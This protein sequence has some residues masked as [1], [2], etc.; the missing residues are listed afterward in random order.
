M[1]VQSL[2]ILSVIINFFFLD[3]DED[4]EKRL[5]NGGMLIIINYS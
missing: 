2:V 3:Y 1:E 5:K 4:F